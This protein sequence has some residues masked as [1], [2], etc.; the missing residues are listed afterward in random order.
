MT[1]PNACQFTVELAVRLVCFHVKIFHIESMCMEEGAVSFLPLS[2]YFSLLP[3]GIMFLLLF[4][5]YLV[6][7]YLHLHTFPGAQLL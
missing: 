1:V 4:A 6:Q 5:N 7:T 3:A 2:V